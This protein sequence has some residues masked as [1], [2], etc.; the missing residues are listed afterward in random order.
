MLGHPSCANGGFKPCRRSQRERCLRRGP[1]RWP[2][3][4]WSTAPLESPWFVDFDGVAPHNRALRIIRQPAEHG[5]HQSAVRCRGVGPCVAEDLKPASLP[6]IAASVFN[7][8]RVDRASRSSRVTISTSRAKKRQSHD[9]ESKASGEIRAR[10]TDDAR[11]C[12]RRPRPVDRLVQG[13]QP[14]S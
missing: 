13:L 10:P 1:C 9:P 8:S 11:Q 2:G 7:R 14:P 12:C 4:M 3:I 5:Q 6:V